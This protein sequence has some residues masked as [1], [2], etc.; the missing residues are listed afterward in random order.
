M[1]TDT[2]GRTGTRRRATVAAV[3]TIAGITG[4]YLIVLMGSCWGRVG[5]LASFLSGAATVAGIWMADRAVS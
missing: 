5:T 2:A 1:Q 4:L 3:T